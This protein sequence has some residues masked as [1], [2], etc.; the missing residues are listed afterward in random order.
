MEET[1]SSTWCRTPCCTTFKHTIYMHSNVYETTKARDEYLRMHFPSTTSSNGLQLD[2]PVQCAIECAVAIQDNL[3]SNAL[4]IGCA[5][6]RA[7]FELARTFRHVTA[8]DYSQSFVDTANT[9]KER[10]CMQYQALLEGEI[11]QTYTAQ[12]D[13]NIVGIN[14][15]Y[16]SNAFI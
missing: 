13:P 7:A 3:P 11:M 16:D 1:V 2:F 5:V 14:I 15:I 9:L 10:G 12:V 8:I 4:D 6:G